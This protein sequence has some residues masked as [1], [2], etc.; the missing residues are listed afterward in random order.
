MK[1]KNI[2]SINLNEA[3]Y[4]LIVLKITGNVLCYLIKQ[5]KI[6]IY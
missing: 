2:T 3:F 6:F 5:N 1:Y 4:S